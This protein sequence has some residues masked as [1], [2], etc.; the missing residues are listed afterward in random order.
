M[1]LSIVILAVPLAFSETSPTPAPTLSLDE[2][3]KA[4]EEAQAEYYR[5]QTEKLKQPTPAKT[6]RQAVDENPASVLGVLGVIVAALVTLLSFVFNYRATLRNQRDTQ[7]YEA[8]KRFGDKDSPSMRS[9]AAGLLAQM[10]SAKHLGVES[11]RTFENGR[12]YFFRPTWRRPYFGTVLYQLVSGLLLEQNHVVLSSIAGALNSLSRLDPNESVWALYSGNRKLQYEIVQILAEFSALIEDMELG[13]SWSLA[14]SF[15]GYKAQVLRTLANQ[16]D[17]DFSVLASSAFRSHV[18]LPA[19]KKQELLMSLQS[20]LRVLARRLRAN[21]DVCSDALRGLRPEKIGILQKFWWE[22]SGTRSMIHFPFKKL[23][24]VGANLKYAI[25]GKTGLVKSLEVGLPYSQL[26][27]AN[28]EHADLQ[29]VSLRGAQ[30]QGANLLNAKMD[31]TKLYGACIDG[32]TNMEGATWWQA[33]FFG[34]V[35]HEFF[36]DSD[37]GEVDAKLLEEL[38]RRYGNTEMLD[39][40]YSVQQFKKL[41]TDRYEPSKTSS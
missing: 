14:E 12:L 24:L 27:A 34:Y 7:F 18:A 8:L 22:R 35:S 21:V 39:L 23:F 6:F 9:S 31:G 15:T 16:S 40:H 37:T 17:Q 38:F 3:R 4:N 29:A 1:A 20:E 33:N 28:L 25:L 32:K 2:A 30:L 36:G 11:M 41:D 5:A 13:D 26:Q 19:E 10:S